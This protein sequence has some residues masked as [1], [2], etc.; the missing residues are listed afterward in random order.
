MP[1]IILFLPLAAAVAITLFFQRDHV[2]SAQLS[3]GAV[4]LSRKELKE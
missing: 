2:F 3:I 4:V 1:W